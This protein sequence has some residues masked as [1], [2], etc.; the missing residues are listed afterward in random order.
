MC[1]GLLHLP[2]Y[3]ERGHRTYCC[4][5]LG[6]LLGSF[7][8]FVCS[9][10]LFED[11][12]HDALLCSRQ[13]GHPQPSCIWQWSSQH[14]LAQIAVLGLI[15][16]AIGLLLQCLLP[17]WRSSEY[18]EWACYENLGHHL[19]WPW[20]LHIISIYYNIFQISYIIILFWTSCANL[21]C[22]LLCSCVHGRS[23][24]AKLCHSSAQQS[25]SS[26]GSLV[27]CV[28]VSWMSP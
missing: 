14:D 16:F 9:Y 3:S 4:K 15:W 22:V 10:S 5:S 13:L 27:F 8:E 25:H 7:T 2:T 12:V 26:P 24:I 23:W 20:V 19:W 28:E 1:S 11:A 18:S 6:A 17:F 21:C